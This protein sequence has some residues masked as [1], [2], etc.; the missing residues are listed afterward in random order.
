MAITRQKKTEI[1]SVLEKG[2]SGAETMVFVNFHGLVVKETTALRKQLRD[3]G[4]SFYV[5]KKTLVKR[6]LTA[7]GVTGTQP[8]LVG[9]LALAWGTDAILPAKAVAEFVKTHKENLSIMGGV[10]QGAYLSKEEV[11]VLASVPSREV[12]YSQLLSVLNAPATQ[13]VSI[14]NNSY[15]GLV[16]VMDQKS[17]QAV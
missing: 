5:A 17:K 11:I 10:Y 8:E 2:F 4:V 7:R 15:K 14:L 16:V 6:A 3:Q 12:L 1:L 13:L 9:E